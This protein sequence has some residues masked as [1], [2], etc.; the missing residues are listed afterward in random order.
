MNGVRGSPASELRGAVRG[1][2]PR[3]SALPSALSKDRTWPV[4][5]QDSEG[6]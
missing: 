5:W 3:V 4:P 6:D 2:G 1:A